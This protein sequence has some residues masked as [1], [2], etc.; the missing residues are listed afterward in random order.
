M[1]RWTVGAWPLSLYTRVLNLRV[2]TYAS[3]PVLT[4]WEGEIFNGTGQGT[5]SD[6]SGRR[7]PLTRAPRRAYRQAARG[8]AENDPDMVSSAVVGERDPGAAG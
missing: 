4:W 2:G 7:V 6:V 3:A 5:T 8:L 1:C